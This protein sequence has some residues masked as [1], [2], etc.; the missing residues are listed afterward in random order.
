MIEPS[1][2]LADVRVATIGF[3]ERGVKG[4]ALNIHRMETTL[5][6]LA[7]TQV[8]VDGNEAIAHLRITLLGYEKALSLRE[9]EIERCPTLHPRSPSRF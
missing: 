7:F 5:S 4:A 6:T 1:V 2:N 3:S 8:N 9:G